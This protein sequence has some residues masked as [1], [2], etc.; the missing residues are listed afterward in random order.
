M[1]TAADEQTP[2]ASMMTEAIGE[3]SLSWNS[4]KGHKKFATMSSFACSFEN[5]ES[6][7]DDMA[8]VR[9]NVESMS[10]DMA[11]PAIE[12]SDDIDVSLGALVLAMGGHPFDSPPP[13]RPPA[14]TMDIPTY[15]DGSVPASAE[16]GKSW[17][18]RIQARI[19]TTLR[20]EARNVKS[21]KTR[22]LSSAKPQSPILQRCSTGEM[23]DEQLKRAT[24]KR[25]ARRSLEIPRP[26]T[27]EL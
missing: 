11:D 20:S 14:A 24:P 22:S 1:A 9:H 23:Y 16:P 8:R 6:V 27:S 26:H 10:A 3:H 13:T 25:A 2:L 15:L 5:V 18:R 4:F 19:L 21:A 17:R 7:S 12:G